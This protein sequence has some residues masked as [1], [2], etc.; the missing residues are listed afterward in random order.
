MSG[1]VKKAAVGKRRKKSEDTSPSSPE[2]TTTNEH[3]SHVISVSFQDYLGTVQVSTVGEGRNFGTTITATKIHKSSR[4]LPLVF[5]ILIEG[6]RV[7]REK[8]RHNAG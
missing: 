3:E 1:V 2:G 5:R 7:S 4:D 8:E 6:V